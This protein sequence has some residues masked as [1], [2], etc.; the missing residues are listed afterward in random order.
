MKNGRPFPFV[1]LAIPLPREDAMEFAQRWNI[2]D[3]MDPLNRFMEAYTEANLQLKGIAK[4]GIVYSSKDRDKSTTAFYFAHN[5]SK[6]G[7][8]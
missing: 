7:E 1:V 3:T 5:G 6:S 2:P 8:E 4:S